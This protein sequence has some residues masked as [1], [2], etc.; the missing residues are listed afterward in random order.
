VALSFM[1]ALVDGGA[2]LDWQACSATGFANYRVVR[3][4]TN[5]DPMYPLNAGTEL[6]ATIG[7]PNTSVLVDVNVAT[8]QTW[9]YRV[10]CMAGDGSVLGITPA[11]SATIP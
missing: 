11:L 4:Q 2:E 1:V 10:L 3:S 7:N 8:G 5:T 9:Y 6:E